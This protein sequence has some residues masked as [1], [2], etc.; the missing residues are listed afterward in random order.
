MNNV[1]KQ[2]FVLGYASHLP[3]RDEVLRG[4]LQNVESALDEEIA[5]REAGP[6]PNND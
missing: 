1:D 5:R 3:I 2:K 6:A 4:E